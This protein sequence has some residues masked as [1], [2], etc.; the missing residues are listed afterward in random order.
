MA[1]G[2]PVSGHTVDILDTIGYGPQIWDGRVNTSEEMQL[3]MTRMNQN[4]LDQCCNIGG[5]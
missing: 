4:Q 1:H 3:F 5:Y 2:K